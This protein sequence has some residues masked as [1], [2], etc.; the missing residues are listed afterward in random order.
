MHL[1]NF[2]IIAIYWIKD[3]FEKVGSYFAIHGGRSPSY[4]LILFDLRRAVLCRINIYFSFHFRFTQSFHPNAATL[5]IFW[6]SFSF[7]SFHF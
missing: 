1:S 7:Y 3:S 6:L 4:K 2:W 5:T